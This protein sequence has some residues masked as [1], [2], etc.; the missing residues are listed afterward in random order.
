M[1]AQR[2]EY[3]G[4]AV[5]SPAVNLIVVAPAWRQ[6]SASGI[7]SELLGDTT[8]D[9]NHIDLLVAVIL[10]GEGDPFPVRREFGN[11]LQTRMRGEA[12]GQS[13]GSGS[14]PEIAGVSEDYFVAMNIRKAKKLGLSSGG[15]SE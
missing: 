13:T 9:G 8:C 3:D 7:K 2:P 10:T 14:E 12:S 6:R 4:L 5:G 1:L 11:Q 15:K